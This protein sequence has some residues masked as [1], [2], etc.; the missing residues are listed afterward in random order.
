MNERQKQDIFSALEEKARSI[1]AKIVFPEGNDPV[2]I[3]A[4]SLL[5][6]RNIATPILL[7]NPEEINES[8]SSAGLNISGALIINPPAAPELPVLAAEYQ[9]SR[10]NITEAVALRLVKKP[11]FFGGMMAHTGAADGMVGGAASPTTSL[12]Q[13]AGLTVGFKHE[14]PSPSSIML[15]LMPDTYDDDRRILGFADPAVNVAPSIEELAASAVESG[16]T[17]RLLTGIDPVVALLS[18]STKGSA[19]HENVSKVAEAARLARQ[20]CDEFPIDGELQADA[21]LSPRVAEKK[22]RDSVVAGKANVLIFPDLD[23]ANIGYKL[24]QHLAGAQAVGPILQGFKKPINDLSRGC[25][26]SDVLK[27][28]I[29]TALQTRM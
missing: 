10:N 1:Q 26:P 20:M 27:T 21:A 9:K 11:M 13:A 16:K 4:V 5:M 24:T 7:G 29:L 8:A 6:E 17:F 14:S 15:M 22:V 19:A 3:E 18:F 2:I 28:T 12:L 23:S 25:S